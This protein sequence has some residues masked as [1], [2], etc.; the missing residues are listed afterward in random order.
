MQNVFSHCNIC[1]SLVVT[2]HLY[3]DEEPHG[4]R[5]C[6]QYYFVRSSSRESQR[7]LLGFSK[8]TPGGQSLGRDGKASWKL[9]WPSQSSDGEGFAPGGRPF[10]FQSALGTPRPARSSEKPQSRASSVGAPRPRGRVA[11]TE[12]INKPHF[13]FFPRRQGNP[14]HFQGSDR[15]RRVW[16]WNVE[17]A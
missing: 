8:G 6:G 14:K 1:C 3:L 11:G 13:D 17:S 2:H 16:E 15:Q 7:S 4:T 12:R 10:S 5:L 9:R